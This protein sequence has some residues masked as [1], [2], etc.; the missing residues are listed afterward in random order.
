M[1]E[2]VVTKKRDESVNMQENRESERLY[3]YALS[4]EEIKQIIDGTQT[5]LQESAV[6]EVIAQAVRRR[7]DRMEQAPKEAHPWLTYWL[8]EKKEQKRGIGLVGCKYLPNEDG[9]VEIGYTMAEEYRNQG[10]MT[11]AL[12]AFLD[13]L[14]EY[15]F[16]KGAKLLIRSANL[17][18]RK[19]A[20]NCG[21]LH[22]GR[23]EI[24]E[25]YQYDF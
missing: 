11:E 2:T 1:Y 23:E 12:L 24:Y 16:C 8:I 4:L 14:Y 6:S 10:Y 13:W 9:Y 5:F 21:F 3:L 15:P 25:V 19:V 7:Y 20:E 18:S 22:Q 17:P